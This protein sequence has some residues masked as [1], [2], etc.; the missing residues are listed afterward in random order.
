MR[1]GGGKLGARFSWYAASSS[2]SSA[3]S[4]WMIWLQSS[5]G[6]LNS[7][8]PRPLQARSFSR[9]SFSCA[10]LSASTISMVSG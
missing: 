3:P 6:D 9:L 10:S 1:L 4:D 8:R 7:K 5:T 2:L